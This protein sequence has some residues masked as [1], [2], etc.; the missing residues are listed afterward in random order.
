MLKRDKKVKSRRHAKSN[1][2]QLAEEGNNH[3]WR[4]CLGTVL[5]FMIL[6]IVSGYISISIKKLIT[7]SGILS[8]YAPYYA[9]VMHAIYEC[10]SIICLF[11]ILKLVHQR[12]LSTVFSAEGKIRFGRLLLAV[13]V[14]S[15]LLLALYLYVQP[16]NSEII[17][18][19]K[20]KKWSLLPMVVLFITIQSAKEEFIYRGYLL[21]GFYFFTHKK[22]LAI[23][24]T[25]LIFASMHFQFF[26]PVSSDDLGRYTSLF[27]HG[28]IYALITIKNQRI[29]W[30][31]G[32][33][34]AWNIVQMMRLGLAN[35]YS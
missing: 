16:T 10:I 23:L 27:V 30:A 8:L 19:I 32:S 22:S 14:C 20:F 28:I 21:Q 29:E 9:L 6:P 31:I 26:V 15:S 34:A 25:S 4:Y 7:I 2:L 24:F 17:D 5:I 12:R 13:V 1:Y 33:H 3:L 11:V 18:T 35:Y